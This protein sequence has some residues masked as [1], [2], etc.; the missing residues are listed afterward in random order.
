VLS[1]SV[2]GVAPAAE[3]PR[4]LGCRR[5]VVGLIDGSVAVLRGHLTPACCGTS[6]VKGDTPERRRLPGQH[7]RTGTTAVSLEREIDRISE[8]TPGVSHR[9]SSLRGHLEPAAACPNCRYR[10]NFA[11]SAL[12]QIRGRCPGNE[13][14][15]KGA[16]TQV[17]SIRRADTAGLE[18]LLGSDHPHAGS[19]SIPSAATEP[20]ERGRAG[21][22]AVVC[23]VARV[24][25]VQVV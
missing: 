16:G 23:V 6:T 22:V 25:W 12:A 9:R 10:G 17:L 7:S 4:A 15:V 20:H 8:T 24:E 2:P 19:F 3:G 11:W 1:P 21:R 18:V 14:Y 13:Q 5:A